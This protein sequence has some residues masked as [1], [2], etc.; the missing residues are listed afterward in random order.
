MIRFSLDGKGVYQ[1]AVKCKRG[2]R[3]NLG[4]MVWISKEQCGF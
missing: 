3:N 2:A 1:G 4:G